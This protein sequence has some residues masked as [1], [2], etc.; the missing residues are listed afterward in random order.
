MGR[1]YIGLCKG[2]DCFRKVSEYDITRN[3]VG[4]ICERSKICSDCRTKSDKNAIKKWR[5][6]QNKKLKILNS[7]L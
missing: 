2:E 6:K 4:E 1:E 7:I 3:S 5:Q